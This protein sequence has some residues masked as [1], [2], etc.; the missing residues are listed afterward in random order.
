MKIELKPR[1]KMSFDI[2][3]EEL[4]KF[5]KGKE[6]IVN[7][8]VEISMYTILCEFLKI[9]GYEENDD[10]ESIEDELRDKLLDIAYENEFNVGTKV[11]WNDPAINEFNEEDREEQLNIIYEIVEI[12]NKSEGIVLIKDEYGEAEVYIEELERI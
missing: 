5:C 6:Y 1:V 12:I 9:D 8:E 11:K 4:Y 2:N 10:S 3:I 7:C